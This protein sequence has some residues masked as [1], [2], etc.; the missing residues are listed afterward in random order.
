[1]LFDMIAVLQYF[2]VSIECLD[3]RFHT[4]YFTVPYFQSQQP[5]LLLFSLLLL[6]PIC[7]RTFTPVLTLRDRL[8]QY[9]TFVKV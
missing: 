7:Q 2:P 3:L 6:L 8:Y 1:M 4:F 9:L 5:S